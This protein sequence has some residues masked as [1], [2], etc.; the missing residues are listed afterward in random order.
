[1]DDKKVDSGI[2]KNYYKQKHDQS[3]HYMKGEINYINDEKADTF[4]D[5]L[6]TGLIRSMQ[7]D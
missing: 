2:S 3:S 5:C 7:R 4:A 1:M 6:I